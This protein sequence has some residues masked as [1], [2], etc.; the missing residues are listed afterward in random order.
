MKIVKVL[1][2][3]IMCKSNFGKFSILLIAY[4]ARAVDDVWSRFESKEKKKKKEYVY[5]VFYEYL[6]L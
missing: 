2:S 4:D 3:S 1:D 6:A 5:Q